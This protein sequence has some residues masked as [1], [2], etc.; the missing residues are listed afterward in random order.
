MIKLNAKT[1][2]RMAAM[3]LAA[4]FMIAAAPATYA[5]GPSG[6]ASD[7]TIVESTKN[8]A[9]GPGAQ[10]QEQQAGQAE[11]QP[12]QP[13]QQPVQ[14]EQ[15][16]V[17]P[18]QQPTQPE[19]Q[20]TQ[21]EQQPAQPEQQPAQST[22]GLVAS[23]GRYLDPTK[24]MV[25]LTFDD[26]PYAPVGNRIMDS[27]EQNNGRATFFVVGNRVA[28]YKTEIKRMHDNGHE[29]G[30]HTYEH[31]YL[32]KL[33]AAQIRSQ[34]ERGN[35]AVAAV[36]GESPALVR[37]PGG[38]KNNTV[39]ANINQPIIM[40][41]IDTLDWKTKNASKTIQSVLGSVKDGDIV[42]MHELYTASGD[43]AVALIPALRERGYQLVTVSE[44]ARFRGGL[45]NKG[46]YYSFPR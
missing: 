33:D 39:L 36:T 16:P 43:A 17:Q 45:S 7:T 22:E 30:N 19:Q 12:V 3:L 44:L 41:N 9:T 37:L 23:G 11:Q 13:E 5:D 14:P 4:A 40:W 35:Q 15:Q 2:K 42:L 21:P 28:S 1:G 38:S 29:I 20:P 26:G 6:P 27:L 10:N 25:A 24:P 31:K 46:V 34:I 18:E 32:N 8:A